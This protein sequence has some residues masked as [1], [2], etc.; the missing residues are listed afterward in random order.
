MMN[1]NDED[2]V[3][4]FEEYVTP[5]YP[6]TLK[7][8]IENRSRNSPQRYDTPALQQSVTVDL[9]SFEAHYARL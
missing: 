6:E 7:K 2:R 3:R 8:A 5:Y 1:S 9:L 4:R